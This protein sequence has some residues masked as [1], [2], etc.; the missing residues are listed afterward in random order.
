MKIEK[1]IVYTLQ[2]YDRE[3]TLILSALEMINNHG[4]HNFVDKSLIENMI[5]IM[6]E[7]K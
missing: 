7:K 1:N 6:E 2:A 5:D 4:S 3:F